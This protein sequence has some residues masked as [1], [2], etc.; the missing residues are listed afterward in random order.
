MSLDHILLG[1]LREPASGY[2]LKKIFDERI[3]HFWTAELSQIYPTL[4]Q[5]EDRGLVSSRP[6]PARRG[7]GRRVYEI[8]APGRDA[9][10]AWLAG[11]PQVGAERIAYLAQLYFMGELD[12]LGQTLRFIRALRGRFAVKLA[13][14]ETIERMWAAAD[15]RYPEGLAA[16]DLHVHFALR[17]GLHSLQA[18]LEWCGE[19]ITTLQRRLAEPG[20]EAG[21]VAR[22]ESL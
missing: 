18:H 22:E 21:A 9:L 4:K 17:K 20:G 7:R 15:P 8:T 11:Q 13:A 3:G 14:L 12:D 1:L 2:D 16:D 10:R 6:A 19:T 5:L